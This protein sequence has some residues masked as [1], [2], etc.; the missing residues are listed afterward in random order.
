ML[1]ITRGYQMSQPDESCLEDQ[2]AP[3]GRRIELHHR[4]WGASPGMAKCPLA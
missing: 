1:V 3:S 2:W 4:G